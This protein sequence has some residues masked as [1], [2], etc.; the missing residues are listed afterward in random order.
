MEGICRE[1]RPDNLTEN[2]R[3]NTLKNLSDI[4]DD[5]HKNGATGLTKDQINTVAKATVGGIADALKGSEE[6]SLAGFG[7]FSVAERAERMGCNPQTGEQTLIK[8]SKAV[9]FKASK[10]LKDTVA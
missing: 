7:K 6:V 8:A 9:K 1:N 3:E 5:I 4:V 10:T 2:R